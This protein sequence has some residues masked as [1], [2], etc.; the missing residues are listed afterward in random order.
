MYL[1]GDKIF[2]RI[3]DLNRIDILISNIT[4]TQLKSAM[5]RI[6]ISTTYINIFRI[7]TEVPYCYFITVIFFSLIRVLLMT[8]IRNYFCVGIASRH[9]GHFHTQ[10][11]VL[12]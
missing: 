3:T 6:R 11:R 12:V 9:A 7:S 5:L 4:V 2:A 8:S 10:A 1:N